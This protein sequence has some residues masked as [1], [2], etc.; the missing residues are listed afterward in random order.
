MALSQRDR[1]CV[2]A[3]A[4]LLLNGWGSPQRRGDRAALGPRAS[5]SQADTCQFDCSRPGRQA[6]WGQAGD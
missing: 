2:A 3:V 5:E 1:T 6:R 4:L